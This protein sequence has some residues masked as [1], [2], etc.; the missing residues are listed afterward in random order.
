MLTAVTWEHWTSQKA[1]VDYETSW[2]ARL[3]NQTC[4]KWM[5][6]LSVWYIKQAAELWSTLSEWATSVHSTL[7]SRPLS[8]PSGTL[9]IIVQLTVPLTIDKLK[10]QIVY[11]TKIAS[12]LFSFMKVIL[13]NSALWS[14]PLSG[15]WFHELR[16]IT[17]STVWTIKLL[18]LM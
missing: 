8:R 14:C 1:S 13:Y 17:D 2:L 6:R 16:C 3:E 12:H 11:C 18:S 4:W 7:Y 15:I 9:Y 10:W 5:Y